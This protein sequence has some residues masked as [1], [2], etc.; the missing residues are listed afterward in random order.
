M[1][2]NV[3]NKSK[4]LQ[5]YDLIREMIFSNELEP[6]SVIVERNLCEKI[7]SSRT[8]VREALQILVSEGMIQTTTSR[9]YIVSDIQYKEVAH[10]YDVRSYLESLAAYLVAQSITD[11]QISELQNILNRMTGLRQT[12]NIN[13]M[14]KLDNQFHY[15]IVQLSR[16]DLLIAIYKHH[17]YDRT[18]RITRLI[19]NSESGMTDSTK[20]HQ[21]LIDALVAHDPTRA[22][23]IMKKHIQLSKTYLMELFAP[24]TIN[25]D[26]R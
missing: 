20:M 3:N 26:F 13:E 24:N 15:K 12:N 23:L 19:E 4:K 8:P 21:D 18:R 5:A 9:G 2:K 17:L 7:G 1:N 22:E 14:L 6:G 10:T 25:Q 11:K 16:N